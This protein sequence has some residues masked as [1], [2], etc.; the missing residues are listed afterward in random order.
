M[1]TANEHKHV[2]RRP[3]TAFAIMWNSWQR[4]RMSC[5]EFSVACTGDAVPT[6]RTHLQ[7]GLPQCV[8][9]LPQPSAKADK[10]AWAAGCMQ[11][12]INISF[13]SQP[14]S[15]QKA[16]LAHVRRKLFPACTPV[17]RL[18]QETSEVSMKFGIS[19]AYVRP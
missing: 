11:Q 5:K 14:Q 17:S 10:G 4:F 13:Y 1:C 6:G 2:T 12:R 16:R 7:G 15:V 9:A 8:P 18:R 19:S 3:R